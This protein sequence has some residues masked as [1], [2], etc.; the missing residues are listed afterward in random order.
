MCSH[1]GQ[2]WTSSLSLSLETWRVQ[3]VTK[4]DQNWEFKWRNV[5]IPSKIFEARQQLL[6]TNF[7]FW[8]WLSRAEQAAAVH[9]PGHPAVVCPWSQRVKVKAAVKLPD[10]ASSS[11]SSRLPAFIQD[12]I[13]RHSTLGLARPYL[14]LIWKYFLGKV[15]NHKINEGRSF[16]EPTPTLTA[17]C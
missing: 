9:R 11:H 17:S 5:K 3:N 12:F 1:Q 16:S 7:I 10:A 14:A 4:S 8:V 2:N 13:Y 15:F 6:Q